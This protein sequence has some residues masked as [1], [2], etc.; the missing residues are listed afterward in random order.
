MCQEAR[1]LITAARAAGPRALEAQM[2]KALIRRLS[3]FDSCFATSKYLS[4]VYLGETLPVSCPPPSS[5]GHPF[6]SQLASSFLGKMNT[7]GDESDP[8]RPGLS[9]QGVP[10]RRE[11]SSQLLRQSPVSYGG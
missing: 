1:Q 5:P 8:Q 4:L 10:G 9:A 2:P 11:P 7:A 6:C 3:C